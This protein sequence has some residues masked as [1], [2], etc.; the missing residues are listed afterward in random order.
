VAFGE[1]AGGAEIFF[2]NAEIHAKLLGKRISHA[3]IR[4]HHRQ[5]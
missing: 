3:P 2:Q 1:A 4:R 5:G